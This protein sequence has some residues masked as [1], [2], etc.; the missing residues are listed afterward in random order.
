MCG[1]AFRTYNTCCVSCVWSQH[2]WDRAPRPQSFAYSVVEHSLRTSTVETTLG[3]EWTLSDTP[4]AG[5]GVRSSPIGAQAISRTREYAITQ[6]VTA[7]VLQMARPPHRDGLFG[8]L[9]DR[10]LINESH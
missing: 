4:R 2:L 5:L 6:Q 7:N 10:T 9:H 8:S 3:S 1:T